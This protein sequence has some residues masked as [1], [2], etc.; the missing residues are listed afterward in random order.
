MDGR[1]TT[2]DGRLTAIEGRLTDVEGRLTTIDGRLDNVEGRLDN[3]D[4]RLDNIEGRI[5][6]IDTHIDQQP[7]HLINT[8]AA[9]DKPLRGP[10]LVVLNAPHPRT[11]DELLLF[12]QNQCTASATALGLPLLPNAAHVDERRRQLARFLGVPY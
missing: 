11:R 7:M 2:M 9:H 4:G 1:L 5:D 6:R 12:T 3:I 10:D 8:V